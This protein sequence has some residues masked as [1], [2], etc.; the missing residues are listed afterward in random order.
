MKS[1]KSKMKQVDVRVLVDANKHVMKCFDYNGNLKWRVE[2]RCDGVYG[3]G[4]NVQGGDTPP[5]L[6]EIGL[7][8]E[9]QPEEP[10]SV[11]NAFGKYFCDL[12][13]LENQEASRGRAGCGVHGGGSASPNPL[14]PRQGWYPTHGCIRLQNE[15]LE[16][17]FVPMCK[18][19][20][21]NK[22]KVYVEVIW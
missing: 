8:T 17:I 18:F 7:I 4:Y 14:A 15:D 21:K 12:V 11:W 16:K 10:R 6:Y 9:S 2:A 13:E 5:G 22:G 1:L 20:K 19:V 3:P